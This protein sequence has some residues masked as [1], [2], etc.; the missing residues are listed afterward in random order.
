MA[1]LDTIHGPEDLRRLT[2]AQTVE[3]ADEIRQFLIEHVSR[4]G[5]HLGPNLGV[6]ELTLAI[7][8]VFSSPQDPIVFDTGHQS[9]V[10]KIITGRADQFETLRQED[11]LS[12]YPSRAE[13][14]HDWVENSHAST[15]LSWAE[16][17]AEG[18]RL[19]GRDRTVVAVIGDGA[20]TGGMAWEAL[21]SIA[22]QQDL[23]LV[24]IVNDNGRSYYP[25]VG[26]LANRLST[27]RT[28]PRYEETLDR[29][30]QLVTDKP[31]G[32]QVYGLMHGVKTGMKDALIGDQGIFSD[33]GIKYL[34]PVDGHDLDALERVLSLAKRY[35]QPVIVHAITSKGKGYPAAEH[36]EEDHFH[37]IG[38]VDPLTG[39]PRGLSKGES[40]TAAFSATMVEIGDARPDVVA[41]TAAMLH[42]VGLASFAAR[43]PDRIFD[44]GIAE[45]H[46]LTS[47][48]GLAA[49]GY[50]PVVALYST[51]LNR[52][53]DQLLM[54]AGL[55]RA[56]VTVV[57]DRAGVTGSDGASHNGMWDTSI[58]GIVP[59]IRL[60]CP[61][62][63][64]HLESVL[65]QAVEVDDGP[66]VIRYSKDHMPALVPVRRSIGGLDVLFQ[67]RGD[68]D[69]IDVLLV[70]HGQV[71]ADTVAAAELLSG[72]HGLDGAGITVVSPRWSLPIDQDLL[73][74]AA[75]ARAVVSVE[76]GLVIGGLGSRLSTELHRAGVWTPVL[77]LGIDSQY[78]P[79]ASRSSLMHRL[80]LDAEG[81]AESTRGLMTSLGED[82][83]GDAR[84]LAEQSAELPADQVP[85]PGPRP[86]IGQEGVDAAR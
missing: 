80:G 71:C 62:D 54:D 85:L 15:S 53:F 67:T 13:S 29:I 35:R 36:D 84:R 69:P 5:G 42:P 77:E 75:S 11:G 31:L 66:T 55:H 10:H 70:A 52:A 81:I 18:I 38:A 9:Y 25:T 21:D 86:Q 61:R 60:S 6:V 26:G 43:F 8:R 79:H 14:E 78:L 19:S 37:T 74:M 58:C 34:G 50:H 32:R 30:K 7:H 44:V 3:L 40:W 48:A 20:L 59:G 47:A 1:L 72:D 17:M 73:A 12:G 82:G 39:R 68:R 46:A 41:I 28:D 64:G 2:D 16:G 65:W 83:F 24:I 22:A 23:R 4:T 49:M 51:F 45:Q 27:I 57:L 56:G 76:D 33:L 63:R